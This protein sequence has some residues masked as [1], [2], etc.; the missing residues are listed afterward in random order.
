MTLE[1]YVISIG[2]VG[3]LVGPEH[4]IPVVDFTLAMQLEDGSI[5]FLM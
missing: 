5:L 3:G 1:H 2:V 4:Q